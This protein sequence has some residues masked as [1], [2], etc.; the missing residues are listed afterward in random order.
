MYE[1]F[2]DKFCEKHKVDKEDALKM[3]IVQEFMKE[4]ERIGKEEQISRKKV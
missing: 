1:E 4:K 3:A 2:L